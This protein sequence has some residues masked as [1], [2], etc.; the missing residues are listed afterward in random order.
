MYA[1]GRE[2][3]DMSKLVDRAKA[4]LLTPR[5]EWPL[6]AAEPET[7]AGLYKNYIV[8]LAAIGPVA[9]LLGTMFFLTALGFVFST[10]FVLVL[11]MYAATLGGVYLFALI[12][13]VLAP[14]FGGQK[15]R[16]QAL[17]TAAY[18][19]TAVF[20]AGIGQLVPLLSSLIAVAGFAY[21]IYLLY[22]GLPVTMK[23]PPEKA[24]GYTAVCVIAAVLI[25]WVC[26]LL[27]F[28][29]MGRGL[30]GGFGGPVITVAG[31]EH[32][33]DD[34]A[35]ALE[36]WAREMEEAGKRVEESAERNEG[37]PSADAVGA[38]VGAVVGGGSEAVPALPA[39]QL[40]GFLPETLGGLP[41]KSASA[42]RNAALGFEVSKARADYSDDAGRS[43]SLEI[44]DTGGARGLIAFAQWAGVEQE[45]EWEGGYERDYRRDGRIFHERWEDEGRRGEYAVIV[46]DRIAV[47]VSGEAGSMDELKSALAAGVDLEGL[48]SAAAA[49]EKPAS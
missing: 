15:D 21:T 45:R 33:V 10:G 38:L 49:Q 46:G 17:K 30:W 42:E 25:S 48:E 12:I 19:L 2:E 29:A 44:N 3:A 28:G 13:D 23:A 7:T 20:V 47:E 8:F 11:L 35:A 36:A 22:L 1:A 32:R 26:A 9:A 16:M 5:T 4:I 43:L 14:R 34:S 6:I 37:A 27:L 24:G 41:R 18:S 31:R 39:D 40:K